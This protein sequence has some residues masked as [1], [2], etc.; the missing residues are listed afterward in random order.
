MRRMVLAG[1]REVEL[2]FG[3]FSVTNPHKQAIIK[4]LDELDETAKKI[5]AVNT[6]QIRDGKLYGY[7]TDAPGFIGPLRSYFGDLTGMNAA[8][9]GA[10]GAARACVHALR[11]NGVRS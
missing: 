1:S 4:Y 7:N 10:G 11:E 2:N 8:V 5:G 9:V 3:G 6:V